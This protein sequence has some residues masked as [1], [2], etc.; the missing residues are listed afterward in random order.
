VPCNGVFYGH[1]INF[2][3]I[4][5]ILWP[6]GKF[7]PVLESCAKKNLAILLGR[8]TENGAAKNVAQDLWHNDFAT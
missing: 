2:V 8:D 6:F 1:L 3:A 7:F 5:Y 4:W